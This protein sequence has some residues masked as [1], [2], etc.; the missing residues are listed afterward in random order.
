[1]GSTAPR[2]LTGAW[3]LSSQARNTG[4]EQCAWI[5]PRRELEL[6]L[7]QARSLGFTGFETWGEAAPGEP[8]YLFS[9]NG[10][11]RIDLG[12]TGESAG[13]PVIRVHRLAF[14]V[15]GGES[16]TGY[17]V[18]LPPDTYDHPPARRDG[19]AVR[20][21]SPLALYQLRGGIASQGRSA[22]CPSTTAAPRVSCG[23]GFSPGAARPSSCRELS[24][25]QASAAGGDAALEQPLRLD[26]WEFFAW[27]R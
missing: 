12:V 16:R 11:L 3:V 4:A 25:S 9:Q 22:S 15:D 14:E 13:R 23:S 2:D 19:I 6:R 26:L 5:F 18:V 20:V 8:F 21:V 17:Q 27:R 1:M 24:L 7:A 10:D